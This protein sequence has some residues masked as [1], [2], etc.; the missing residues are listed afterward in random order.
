L[1]ASSLVAPG[2]PGSSAEPDGALQPMSAEKRGRTWRAA[3]AFMNL[4][5]TPIAPLRRT[6]YAKDFDRSRHR[7][8]VIPVHRLNARVNA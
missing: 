2:S 5:L 6:T 7:L 8:G 1:S 3:R 4:T